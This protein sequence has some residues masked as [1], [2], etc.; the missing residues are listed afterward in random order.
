MSDHNI[1]SKGNKGGY[2]TLR[3]NN[4]GSSWLHEANVTGETVN[5]MRI[6]NAL[7]SANGV[8]DAVG[9]AGATDAYFAYVKMLYPF[10]GADAA[11]SGA[12][13]SDLSGNSHTLTASG[14]AQ[15][16]TAESADGVSSLLLDGTED[17]VSFTDHADVTLGNSNFVIDGFWMFNSISSYNRALCGHFGTHGNRAWYYVYNYTTNKLFFGYTTN[18]TSFTTIIQSNTWTPVLYAATPTFYHIAVVR[19]GSNVHF[20]VDG[21]QQGTTSTAISTDTIFDSTDPFTI[22]I[23]DYSNPIGCEFDGWIGGFRYTVG[24]DRGWTSNFTAPTAPFPT[25]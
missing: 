11:T 9:G 25:S 14:H 19:S 22:G 1:I 8:A 15:I 13:F 10:D 6:V 2:V 5:S 3:F 18:G 16:D 17:F 12:G 21:V 24:T 7:W 23:Y 20:F 4:S